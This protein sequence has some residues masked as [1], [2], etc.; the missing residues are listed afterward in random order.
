MP[1]FDNPWV[2]YREIDLTEVLEVG[3]V[4]PQHMHDH[5][6]LILDTSERENFDSFNHDFLFRTMAVKLLLEVL[7]ILAEASTT[8]RL[9]AMTTSDALLPPNMPR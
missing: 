8:A 4:R 6:A 2:D 1:S 9:N 5:S 7:A 3:I